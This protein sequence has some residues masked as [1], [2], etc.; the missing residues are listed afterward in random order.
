M[1]SEWDSLGRISF[2]E[3]ILPISVSLSQSSSDTNMKNLLSLSQHMIFALS[4]VSR[5]SSSRVI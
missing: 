5:S 4:S 2:Y 3:N 1:Y